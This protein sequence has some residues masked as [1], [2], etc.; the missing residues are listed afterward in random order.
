[1]H[2]YYRDKYRVFGLS[3]IYTISVEKLCNTFNKLL[4][5]SFSCSQSDL[6]LNCQAAYY[7]YL[8]YLS[9]GQ[10]NIDISILFV[11]IFS[12]RSNFSLLDLSCAG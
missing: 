11:H 1:M 9:S 2:I 3:I 6:S 7:L 10:S 8:D 5:F 4:P 12:N